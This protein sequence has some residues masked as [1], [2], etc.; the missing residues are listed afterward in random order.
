MPVETILLV[1]GATSLIGDPGGKDDERQ[2]K[3]REEIVQNVAGIRAQVERLFSG[4]EYIPVDNYDW[5]KDIG[6]WSFY[7][8]LASTIV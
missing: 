5:F 7:A 6:Y 2:L 3:S 4:K 8:M 1:G